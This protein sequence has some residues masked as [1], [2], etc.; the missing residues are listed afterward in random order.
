MEGTAGPAPSVS[1][2]MLTTREKGSDA[3]PVSQRTSKDASEQGSWRGSEYGFEPPRA[4]TR[5]PGAF[6][7]AFGEEAN[8]HE[9]PSTEWSITRQP[10]VSRLPSLASSELDA[11]VPDFAATSP[12]S[13]GEPASFM[14]T[15]SEPPPPTDARSAALPAATANVDEMA[16]RLYDRIRSKLRTELRLDRERAGLLTDL[17]R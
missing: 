16:D 10:T 1:V 6:T 8:L 3:R 14:G 5:L 4:I 15:Q 12:A 13:V 7:T 11:R 17:R 9:Q 2:Q